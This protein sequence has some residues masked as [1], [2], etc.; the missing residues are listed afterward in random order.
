MLAT[1]VPACRGSLF[2]LN[3]ELRAVRSCKATVVRCLLTSLYLLPA[4][5][6]LR[7]CCQFLVKF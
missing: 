5:L 2:P 3:C 6:V 4:C 1:E 7:T